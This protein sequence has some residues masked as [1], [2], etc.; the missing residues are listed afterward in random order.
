MLIEKYLKYNFL[1]IVLVVVIFVGISIQDGETNNA[2]TQL[3]KVSASQAV[4]APTQNITVI[5]TSNTITK[6]TGNLCKSCPD[7]CRN[8]DGKKVDVIGELGSCICL[9]NGTDCVAEHKQIIYY[10]PDIKPENFLGSYVGYEI[11]SSWMD[12]EPLKQKVLELTMNENDDFEK[13]KKIANWVKSSKEYDASEISIANTG[14]TIIDIFDAKI[15]VCLDAA[16]LT[17]AMMRSAGI[18]AIPVQPGGKAHETVLAYV[19]NEWVYF[20]STFGYGDAIIYEYNEYNQKNIL[21]DFTEPLY[22]ITSSYLCSD[23][24][25]KFSSFNQYYRHITYPVSLIGKYGRITI[26]MFQDYDYDIEY[27]PPNVDKYHSVWGFEGNKFGYDS[28]Y[29]LRNSLGVNY[30]LNQKVICETTM[31]E[32][33]IFTDYLYSLP[34]PIGKYRITYVA[35]TPYKTSTGGGIKYNSVA[36]LNFEMNES[37]EIKLT[38]QDFIKSIDATDEE[39][40]LFQKTVSK[41]LY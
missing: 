31:P 28:Y 21:N 5:N 40:S 35:K 41:Q 2:Y 9:N 11:Y 13:A 32:T 10:V 20:D 19:N 7:V 22:G 34:L 24:Y 30:N 4:E 23:K 37:S 6:D 33:M 1:L 29:N 14:G 18:P 15:G 17:T 36:I 38:L 16:I 39:Y 27:M 12:Y 3:S 25:D 26:P 8:D